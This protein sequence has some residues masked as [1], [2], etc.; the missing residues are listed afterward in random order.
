LAGTGQ[1][2]VAPDFLQE[3]QPNAVII[4]NAIYKNE[5]RQD[6]QEMGLSPEILTMD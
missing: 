1:L 6:L 3:Y 5:I 2:I 4:M